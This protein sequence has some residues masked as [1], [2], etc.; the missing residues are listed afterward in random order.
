MNF[1]AS[2]AFLALSFASCSNQAGQDEAGQSEAQQE[3]G[4]ISLFDGQTLQGWR[5]S[6]N[7]ST[8]KVENGAIVVNGPR[9]HL[10]YEGPVMNHDFRNFELMAEV[11]TTP[12]SNSGVFVHTAYQEAGWPAQGHEIQVEN[13]HAD[14]RR[15]G[16]LI[17]VVDVRE[18]P[19]RDDEWFTLR[20]IVRGKRVQALV[21]DRS[22]MEYNEPENASPSRFNGGT[23]ALQG[24]DPVSRVYYRNIRVRALPD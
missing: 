8:F 23:I 17:N 21:N 10:F 9:A 3:A 20:I 22:V 5:A 19:A 13:S 7:P 11:M 14:P 6:E 4:W 2:C 12:G 15:T 24:H 16:S 1:L 18:A